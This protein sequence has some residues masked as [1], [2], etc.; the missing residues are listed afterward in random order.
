MKLSII[1]AAWNIENFIEQALHSCNQPCPVPVEVIVV[2]DRS[3]DRTAEL[4][5]RF[6]DTHGHGLD[7]RL[8]SKAENAGL[9][10]ARNTGLEAAT[11]D[12][13]L[14]LDG[15]DWFADG[16]LA[17]LAGVIAQ[18]DPDVVIF[19]HA[20][21]YGNGRIT[22]NT[23]EH[24]LIERA[25]YTIAD[26]QALMDTFGVAW[27][28]VYR[29][30][31]LDGLGL[32]FRVGLYEDINWS[33][34]ILLAAGRLRTIPDVGVYYRQ[35]VGSITR[36]TSPAHFD[37]IGEYRNLLGR[38]KANPDLLTHYG[39]AL[40]RCARRQVFHVFDQDRIP[41][42]MRKTYIRDA[43]AHMTEWREALKIRSRDTALLAWQKGGYA[44]YRAL[45]LAR[46]RVLKTLD[47]ARKVKRA[48][49]GR[50]RALRDRLRRLTA[51]TWRRVLPLRDNKVFFESYWGAKADCNPLAIARG[52]DR[53]GGYDIVW[54]FSP[55]ATIPADFP[56]RTVTR[57]SAA[58]LRE[59]ASAKYFVSNANLHDDIAKRPGAVHLQTWHGT[60][61]KLMGI[62]IR[63]R[64]PREMDWNQFVTRSLRWDYMLSSNPHSSYAWRR[65]CPYHYK[66]LETGYPRNDVFFT[67]T[68]ADRARIRRD[69]G[70]PEG[71][72]IALY[73]PTMRDDLKGQPL[74][75]TNDIFDADAVAAALGEDYV[76]L[77]RAHYFLRQTD[78]S[79]RNAIDVSAYPNSNDIALI[80]DLLITDYSSLMFDYA[81]LRRPVVLYQYDYDDYLQRRGVY[82]D[83]STIPP[84]PIVATQADLI[85]CLHR[86]AFDTAESRAMITT[87]AETFA[88]WDDGHAT[89]RVIEQV[90]GV[91]P[92]P[93]GKDGSQ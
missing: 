90:F 82:F 84:G 24:L 15:D 91:T 57:G 58:M 88:P 17:R 14:F 66:T 76:L 33:F 35:R 21:V 10:M 32:R 1:I 52:L 41:S 37:V 38:L 34:P 71:K 89:D 49:L 2:D 77:I 59:A 5:R 13:I 65:S 31:F 29:R 53:I 27:N 63:P 36:S 46:P 85:D 20:R 69:L 8:I 80:T 61:L 64:N 67:A 25:D 93:T 39:E 16:F 47:R 40:Y 81:C 4:V 45:T 70:L 28:K 6:A 50:A 30:S 44:G 72:K 22:R 68:E 3:T 92:R 54:S 43:F 86:R 9:G 51:A 60:P 11:G 74:A 18:H 56:W 75:I 83:I 12:Y 87:F 42:D 73:A 7:L 78:G 23:T 62:D 26:R 19:S 55:S 79:A 48:V